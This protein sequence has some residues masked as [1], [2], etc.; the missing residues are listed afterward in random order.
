MPRK[1]PAPRIYPL[2]EV[3]GFPETNFTGEA[4]RYRHNKWC[5]FNNPTGPNCTKDS[6]SDPLGVCSVHSGGA[7]I[8][9]CPVR[10]RQ[11]WRIVE[12]A[13]R[14]FFPNRP[15][16]APL[17]RVL[18]EVS[19]KDGDGKE[20]GNI[21][22][23]LLD[24]DSDG[25]IRDYGALEVQAV[26]ISGTVRPWFRHFMERADT[27][28]AYLGDW[29]AKGN[30][31][32]D[33]LSSSRKRLAPQLLYK[34][35]LL[36]HWKRKIAVAVQREFFATMPRFAQVAPQ[37]ADLA[38]LIY[39]LSHDASINRYETRLA[40]TVYTRFEAALRTFT[41]PPLGDEGA[42]IVELQSRVSLGSTPPDVT[43]IP[44]PFSDESA[45]VDRDDESMEDA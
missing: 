19:L 32:P 11:D 8:I 20:A 4:T 1:A 15:A 33:F 22:L 27:T 12:D 43:A 40:E 34:G 16:T 29:P 35:T 23:V 31:R 18:S 36:N 25:M 38:W 41:I 26:Y 10:F 5:P 39:D 42:F 21:D 6:I 30:P 2:A 9:T 7:A 13:A 28:D 37:D 14:F 45:L 17:P 24:L 44:N 3:F